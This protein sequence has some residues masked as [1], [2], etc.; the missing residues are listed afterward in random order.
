MTVT[1]GPPQGQEKKV[2]SISF[3]LCALRITRV[4]LIE[5]FSTTLWMA[6]LSPVTQV[7]E[8]LREDTV[9]GQRQGKKSTLDFFVLLYWQ[10]HP[11]V[12]EGWSLK[13]TEECCAHIA[14]LHFKSLSSE[15]K[16][17]LNISSS[18]PVPLQ[19]EIQI[20][21]STDFSYHP[22]LSKI[23]L[24]LIVP[25]SVASTGLLEDRSCVFFREF[26]ALGALHRAGY[27]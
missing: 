2:T 18:F 19:D 27:K 14:Y 25:V 5:I 10:Q 1:F 16:G 26:I 11:R 24:H 22:D 15:E 21:P 8:C 3:Q 17:Q 12:P 9:Q 20:C 6:G 23:I 7:N 13:I 4:Y